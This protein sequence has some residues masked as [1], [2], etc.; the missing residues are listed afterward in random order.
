[1][2]GDI[3]REKKQNPPAPELANITSQI[4]KLTID[5]HPTQLGVQTKGVMNV[6]AFQMQ[7]NNRHTCAK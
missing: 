6:W 7:H 4:C 3:V 2:Q 5:H 1:M